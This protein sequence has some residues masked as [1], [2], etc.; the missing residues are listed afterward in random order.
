MASVLRNYDEACQGS[1]LYDPILNERRILLGPDRA[2]AQARMIS[3]HEGFHAFLNASTRHGVAMIFAG[4]LVERGG[5]RFRKLVERLIHLS[6]MTHE[7][8][9]TVAGVAASNDTVIDPSLLA[10][11]PD[12]QSLLAKFEACF[13]SRDRPVLSVI[14]LTACARAAMQ[15]RIYEGLA[16]TA[17]AD[18]PDLDLPTFGVPDKRFNRMFTPENARKAVAA[19]DSALRE[20]RGCEALTSQGLS[21]HEE[22]TLW[23]EA[24]HAAMDHAAHA[25]FDAFADAL[26]RETGEHCAFDDQ[27]VELESLIAKVGAFG[28][29]ALSTIFAAPATRAEDEEAMFVDFRRERLV[30]ADAPL[31]AAFVSAAT[32]EISCAE[33]FVIEAQADR[34]AQLVLMPASKARALYSTDESVALLDGSEDDVLFGLRRRWA[35]PGQAP[36]VEYFILQPALASAA[37]AHLGGAELYAQCALSALAT[38]SWARDW[39]LGD[40]SP[41]QRIAVLIDT[42]PFVLL[43]R[44]V[45]RGATPSLTYLNVKLADTV[46]LHTEVLCL[47]FDD[48]PDVLYF[49]PCSA[50]LRL[51]VIHYASRRFPHACFDAAF[52]QQWLPMIGRLSAHALREEACFGA[53]FWR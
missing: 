26:A 23:L 22:R 10:F 2:S 6:I 7:T 32:H 31:P 35:P 25:A 24:P 47:A 3:W 8:Y 37:L 30:L 36:C 42:D 52:I 51:A 5:V 53:G 12:Y 50:P 46:D 38:P 16:Q 15:T 13:S 9:A 44:G 40:A 17:C 48:E 39:L 19:M 34:Y 4:G 1:G 29:A 14:A 27:K 18:W 11:Y 41:V 33:I 43:S 45:K 49:T 28:G 21:A 20:F